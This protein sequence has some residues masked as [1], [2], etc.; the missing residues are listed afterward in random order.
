ML[1]ANNVIDGPP[2]DTFLPLNSLGASVCNGIVLTGKAADQQVVDR[3][4]IDN[5]GDVFIYATRVFFEVHLIALESPLPSLS[6]FPLV[7]PD[8]LKSRR[9]SLQAD[10]KAAYTSKKFDDTDIFSS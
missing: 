7:G 2:K 4:I 3:N 8:R 9:S 5:G 6:R 1:Q 10:A